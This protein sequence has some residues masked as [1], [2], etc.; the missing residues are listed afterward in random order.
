MK[1][2]IKRTTERVKKMRSEVFDLI[3]MAGDRN[4]EAKS[5][6]RKKKYK[7]VSEKLW[8]SIENI[9]AAVIKLE[10]AHDLL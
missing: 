1:A 8:L 5:D 2:D 4:I 9:A 6:D 7:D 3:Q 10:Q